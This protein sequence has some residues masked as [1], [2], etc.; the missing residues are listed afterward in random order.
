MDKPSLLLSADKGMMVKGG[1]KVS[2]IRA[3]VIK[4]PK[5]SIFLH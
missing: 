4:N 5:I 2:E 3:H 1:V